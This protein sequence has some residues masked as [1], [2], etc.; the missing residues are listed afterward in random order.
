MAVITAFFSVSSFA[1][2]DTSWSVPMLYV[3]PLS[4]NEIKKTNDLKECY[5]ESFTDINIP[6][7]YMNSE[8]D[9]L[10]KQYNSYQSTFS[11]IDGLLAPILSSSTLGLGAVVVGG[12]ALTIAVAAKTRSESNDSSNMVSGNGDNGGGNGGDN[13]GDNGGGNG[14]GNDEEF[15]IRTEEYNKNLDAYNEI[16][17]FGALTNTLSARN[18]NNRGFAGD[19]ITVA[20]IDSGVDNSHSDLDDNLI[21]NCVGDDDCATHYA[22]EDVETHGTHVAGIVAAE[23][24]DSGMHG[25]AF[26]ATILPG[27]ANF[28][29]SCQDDQYPTTSDLL[30]WASSNGAHIVNRSLGVSIG[31]DAD[32][33]GMRGK[34]A[35][36]IVGEPSVGETIDYSHDDLKS[37][38]NLMFS[39]DGSTRY[40]DAKAA[41]KQ[42][43]ISIVAAGN[44]SAKNDDP[45]TSQAGIQAMAPLIY[46]GTDMADDIDRQ[47][48]AVINVE[49]NGELSDLSHACGDAKD[50]CLAAPGNDIYSTV[51]GDEYAEKTGTSMSTPIVSGGV[52][53]VMGAFPNLKL[54]DSDAQSDICDQGSAQYNAKQCLSK[55]VVNRVLTTATDLGEAGVDS[56]FGHGMID[57]DAATSLIGTAEIVTASGERHNVEDSS[58]SLSPVMGDSLATTLSAVSFVA[59][60][61]YDQADFVYQGSSLVGNATQQDSRVNS[62][63]YLDRSLK[64]DSNTIAINNGQLSL[65][66]TFQKT[67]KSDDEVNKSYRISYKTSK[68]SQ[69]DVTTSFNPR[70]DF[71]MSGAS[72]S[73]LADLTISSAFNSPY[74]QFNEDA[75]GIT[76]QLSFGG[77]Y[78]FSSGF[79]KSEQDRGQLTGSTSLDTESMIMQ[80]NTPVFSDISGRNYS[81]GLQVGRLDEANS[82]LGTSG[83][84]VWGFNNGSETFITGINLN[85]QLSNNINLLLSYFY[86]ETDTENGGGLL[87]YNNN[88]TSN[89][90]S[91]GLLGDIDQFWQYGLF[92]SQPLRL[93]QGSATLTLPNGF[94]KQGMTFKEY[95]VDFT[96]EGRHFEYEF[97]LSWSAEFVDY[98]RLNILRVVDYGSISGNNDTMVLFSAG[99]KF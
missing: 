57:L 9:D 67:Y 82:I 73:G 98:M 68:N 19:G 74:S 65:T 69:V 5:S 32:A 56:V 66:Q 81:V 72:S 71:A 29:P 6:S 47:W 51:P 75:Q 89:S 83:S 59:V 97:A 8:N 40:A 12:A 44:H 25:V 16:G 13:G 87:N 76:Y 26:N 90:F 50:F 21:K 77:G 80:I 36:D 43:V 53:L 11:F 45:E 92:V 78:T 60:D 61:S 99:T 10:K 88:F 63:E 49:N 18:D 55:A 1:N 7:L 91:I 22:S 4:C 58:I 96:P 31:S 30:L 94:D 48:L 14:G 95:D 38:N 86:S 20:V 27:C 2:N 42:G 70:T 37:I 85:Y 23:R 33:D 64:A 28:D 35:S 24:N 79:F 39:V 62:M 84:G 93:D 15:I 3:A 52:A 46:A 17:L 54:P 41:F 34:V